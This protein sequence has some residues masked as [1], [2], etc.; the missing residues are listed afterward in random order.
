MKRFHLLLAGALLLGAFAAAGYSDSSVIKETPKQVVSIDFDHVY[1][2]IDAAEVALN[3]KIV[4]PDLGTPKPF[5]F[6]GYAKT[7]N[8]FTN[9]IRP[10][11]DGLS[12]IRI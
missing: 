5:V 6:I 7:P 12:K 2:A 4:H 10:P 11:P 9:R 3:F 1:L 8:V